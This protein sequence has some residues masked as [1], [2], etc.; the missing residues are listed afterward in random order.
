MK[1][2]TYVSDNPVNLGRFGVIEKN[3]TLEVTEHEWL[4]IKNDARFKHRTPKYN[5]STLEAASRA[6]PYATHP[7]DLRTIPWGYD[8]LFTMLEARHN[9]LSLAKLIEGLVAVGAPV[10]DVSIHEHRMLIVDA[11]LE[12]AYLCGWHKLTKEELHALPKLEDAPKH[13]KKSKPASKAK[14]SQENDTGI[15]SAKPVRRRI[16]RDTT[17]IK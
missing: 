10:R 16:R 8:N 17:K 11:I 9:K 4:G 13:K 15:P 3:Q 7:F 6:M 5:E 12:S 1:K 14:H 2:V